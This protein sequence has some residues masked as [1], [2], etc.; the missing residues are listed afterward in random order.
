MTNCTAGD[1]I[2]IVPPF[3]I[4]EAQVA[5]GLQRMRA[6]LA[7]MPSQEPALAQK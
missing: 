5:E 7:T 1:V 3:V 2:R 6:T 4:T